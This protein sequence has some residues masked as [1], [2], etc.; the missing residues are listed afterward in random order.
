MCHNALAELAKIARAKHKQSLLLRSK[1]GRAT[2]EIQSE[3]F[4]KEPTEMEN[5]ASRGCYKRSFLGG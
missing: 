3:F 1:R 5:S 2:F 4:C